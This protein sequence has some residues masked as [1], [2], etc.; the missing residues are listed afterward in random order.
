MNI[1]RILIFKFPKCQFTI[2]DTYESLE[3]LETELPKPTIEEIEAYSKEFDAY[4]ESVS[5]I[6]GRKKEYPP[7][8]SLITA[9]WENV[10]ENRPEKSLELQKTREEVKLKYPKL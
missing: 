7:I 10:I 3:W 4:L 9:L 2:G 6:E 1:A 8:E 5:Y